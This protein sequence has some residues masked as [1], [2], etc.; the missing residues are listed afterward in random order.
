MAYVNIQVT[1]DSGNG[2]PLLTFLLICCIINYYK[3]MNLRLKNN[4]SLFEPK[5]II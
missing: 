1:E 3:N 4:N 2:S 5:N